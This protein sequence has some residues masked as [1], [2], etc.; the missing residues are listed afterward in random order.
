MCCLFIFSIHLLSQVSALADKSINQ[1]SVISDLGK[2]DGS[3]PHPKKDQQPPAVLQE[4]SNTSVR[5]LTTNTSSK[6][7]Q[8]LPAA[9]TG[10]SNV[11]GPHAEK[12]QQQPQ[13]AA[14][15]K[16]CP[17]NVS[18]VEVSGHNTKQVPDLEK[19]GRRPTALP[20]LEK[21]GIRSSPRL[22]KR[23][24]SNDDQVSVN[25]F[26]WCLFT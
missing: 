9:V 7:D 5:P 23:V 21:V 24:R 25:S 1:L 12:N 8:Q 19:A 4:N 17:I 14:P 10:K 15:E 2:T 16:A 22:A 26:F 18:D 3:I 20:D 6:K 11:M 13:T